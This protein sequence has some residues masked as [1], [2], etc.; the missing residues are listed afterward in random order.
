MS[1]NRAT[2]AY[3]RRVKRLADRLH[4]PAIYTSGQKL[5]AEQV[6]QK[7]EPDAPRYLLEDALRYLIDDLRQGQTSF[8]RT[9]IGYGKEAER[10]EAILHEAKRLKLIVIGGAA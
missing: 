1:L 8:A 7:F 2:K 10:F 9:A 5:T 3:Q 6:F 4:Y